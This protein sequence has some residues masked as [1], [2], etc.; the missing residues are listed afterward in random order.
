MSSKGNQ[1][2][3]HREKGETREY[4]RSTKAAVGR[5]RWEKTKWVPFIRRTWKLS[6]PDLEDQLAGE[7]EARW[8]RRRVG[9]RKREERLRLDFDEGEAGLRG[10]LRSRRGRLGD[11]PE[12]ADELAGET[13]NRRKV[14]FARRRSDAAG[15][16]E[17]CRGLLGLV[18]G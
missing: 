15:F 16:K 12:L 2:S 11:S 13:A 14:D 5:I 6:S 4:P 7:T 1:L 9:S 17:R 8:R 18:V 10:W 3:L